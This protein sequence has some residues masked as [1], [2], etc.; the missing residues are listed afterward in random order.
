MALVLEAN[1]SKISSVML[2]TSDILIL[3]FATSLLKSGQIFNL[4]NFRSNFTLANKILCCGL[5][6][7]AGF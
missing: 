4:H 2:W 6:F 3:S 7:S 1:V 5:I